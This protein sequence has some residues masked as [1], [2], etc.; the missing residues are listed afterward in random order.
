MSAAS[1]AATSSSLG[2]SPS[3]SALVLS[4]IK[5]IGMPSA[6]VANVETIGPQSATWVGPG[7][8][9]ACLAWPS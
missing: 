9:P 8:G 4:Q 1:V 5:A 2:L 3:L 6:R 7:P